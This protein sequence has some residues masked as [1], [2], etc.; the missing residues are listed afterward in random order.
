MRIGTYFF[1]GLIIFFIVV[2]IIKQVNWVVIILTLF[3]AITSIMWAIADGSREKEKEMV[4]IVRR[5]V[6]ALKEGK[7]ERY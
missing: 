7:V 2:L 4:D 6:K 3:G 5:R 1:F